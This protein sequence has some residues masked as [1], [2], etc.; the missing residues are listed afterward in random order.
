MTTTAAP[1]FFYDIHAAGPEA[2]GGL[3]WGTISAGM[4]ATIMEGIGAYE[5]PAVR[6]VYTN[7]WGNIVPPDFSNPNFMEAAIEG[8]ILPVEITLPGTGV[9]E[10]AKFEQFTEFASASGMWTFSKT[11]SYQ[12]KLP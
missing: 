6:T 3:G 9:P 2:S 8:R 12:S 10:L 4:I 11:M 5:P 1:S 7:A